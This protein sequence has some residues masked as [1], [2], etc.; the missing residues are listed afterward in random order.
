M[1]DAALLALT[2]AHLWPFLSGAWPITLDGPAHHYAARLLHDLALGHGRAHEFYAIN[3][4][5]V[6]NLLG[7]ALMAL[8][9]LVAPPQYAMHALL[10][11]IGAGTAS[12]F[13]A[14]AR[15]L[16]PGQP[17]AALWA[18]P[19][20][21]TFPLIMGFLNFCLGI[22]VLLWTMAWLERRLRCDGCLRAA[23]L[24][25]LLLVAY[26]AHL[27]AFLA[28]V[29]WAV[30]RVLIDD[31]LRW[32]G[33]RSAALRPALIA[34]VPGLALT[35]GYL[36]LHGGHAAAHHAYPVSELLRWLIDG[37]AWITYA[38]D[39]DA[40]WTRPMAIILLLAAGI[41]LTLGLLKRAGAAMGWTLPGIGVLLAYFLAP[42]TVLGGSHGSPRLL[43]VA[44]LLLAV[45]V[46]ALG[47]PQRL[48]ALLLTALAIASAGHVRSLSA[49]QRGLQA[50]AA[51]H[52]SLATE[53]GPQ[54]VVLPINGSGNWLHANFSSLVGVRSGAIVLDHFTANAPFSIVRWRPERLPYAAIGDFDR[55]AAPCLRIDGYRDAHGAPLVT[56][57]LAYRWDGQAA[58]SCTADARAQLAAG[59]RVAAQAAGGATLW[60]RR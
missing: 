21:V 55:S 18:L 32:A 15:A 22:A 24:M 49:A 3:P 17:W 8:A 31:R 6:P 12:G 23:P 19:F 44:M 51:D 40:A 54:D 56:H 38:Y 9:M 1:A 25:L 26:C 33:S 59:F 47:L 27:S 58:D 7:Q 53:L 2:A 35:G 11:I 34:A 41:A 43:L 28:A 4:Y 14:L 45:Q 39:A 16:A 13:R 57:V 10:A 36:A 60:S 5:P 37:R 52:V 46:V 20:L 42:D 30:H 29:A 48:H 50:D